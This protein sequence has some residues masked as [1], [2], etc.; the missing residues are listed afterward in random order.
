MM[1]SN[2]PYF[3]WSKHDGPLWSEQ[4]N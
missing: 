1:K 3:T 4:I 2:V